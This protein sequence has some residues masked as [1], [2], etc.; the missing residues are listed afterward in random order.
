MINSA[1][2]SADCSLYD[3]PVFKFLH[4][5]RGHISWLREPK[6]IIGFIRM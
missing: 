4:L 6:D 3:Y 5:D 2:N 1:I